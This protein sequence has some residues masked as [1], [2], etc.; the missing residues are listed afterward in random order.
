[1]SARRSTLAETLARQTAAGELYERLDGGRVRCLACAHRCEIEPGKA[2]ICRVR[3]NR[4]GKLFVPDGY[5]AGLNVDPI[6]KKPFFHALPGSAALSIGM[7]GCNFHCDFCQN[8]LSSQPLRDEEARRGSLMLGAAVRE[9]TAER[10]VELAVEG[11]CASITSTYNEPLISAEWAAKVFRLAQAQGLATGFV[12][13]GHATPEALEYLRP[14]LDWFKV[15]LKSFREESYR[16]LGGRLAAVLETIRGLVER[17]FWVEVVTL[18][19]PGFN[20]SAEELRGIAGFLAGVSAEIPWH[21]TAFH[22]DYR[23]DDRGRTP[24]GKLVEAAE[25]GRAA[26]LRYVY[27]GNV[28]GHAGG[29]EDTRC[30]GCSRLLVKRTGFSV[31]ENLVVDGKCPQCG[32]RIAG[33]W[34]RPAPGDG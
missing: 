28:P 7:L 32:E 14:V 2:G 18:V 5:V 26:G 3:L 20:D 22:P 15:D 1:M 19:V 9:I 34:E 21:V 29:L 30:P 4:A 10:L 17:G 6:E 13:N 24:T 12:S 27:A 16:R 11:G 23:M 31:A 8:W 25:L 33:V